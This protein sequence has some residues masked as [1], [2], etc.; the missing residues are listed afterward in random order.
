MTID[1]SR[2]HALASAAVLALHLGSAGAQASAPRKHVLAGV[3]HAGRPVRLED[4]AGKVV[5]VSFVTG[6]CAVCTSE[7]RLIREFF[8]ANQSRGFVQL[9]VTLDRRQPDYQ[10]LA[11]Y[12]RTGV[13]PGQRF[14]VLWR[15]DPAHR[16]SFGDLARTPTH[17]MLDRQGAEVRRR[18]G[19]MQPAD[20]DEL[21]TLI[22]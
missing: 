15:N 11:E 9:V 10:A 8:G 5:M 14:P 22:G 17:V 12:M 6:D 20:W 21:W 13:P 19:G 2:R 4:F 16:D 7:L 3:D 18:P 1:L